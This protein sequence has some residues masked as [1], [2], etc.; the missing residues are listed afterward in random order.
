MWKRQAEQANDTTTTKEICTTSEDELCITTTIGEGEEEVRNM[1][2][3]ATIDDKF[4]TSTT[5]GDNTAIKKA[6]DLER[7]VPTSNNY[8]DNVDH[9]IL[10]TEYEGTIVFEGAE[11]AEESNTDVN[12]TNGNNVNVNII[13]DES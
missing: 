9:E 11:D 7:T 3:N 12:T 5:T 10:Q 8:Y 13:E 2:D 1:S 4:T 6:E